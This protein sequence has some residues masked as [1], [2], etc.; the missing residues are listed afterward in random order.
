[1]MRV[2]VRRGDSL[3]YYSQLFFIPLPL[4]AD[5]N[6]SI[7]PNALQIGESV[8]IPGFTTEN[9]Y[10]KQG[11]SLWTVARRRNLALDAL[12]LLNP[13]LNPNNLQIGDR[14]IV[15]R[16]VVARVIEERRR[17]GSAQ[18]SADV[19]TL[20]TIYPFI[21]VTT[22]GRSVDNKPIR[23]MKIG[24]G[25]KKVHFNGSFH[26]NEWITSS[27][28]MTFLNDYLL[29]LTNQMAI[30]GIQAL[31][32]YLSTNISAVPMVNPDGVDLVLNGPSPQRRD[33]LIRINNGSTDFS[34]WKANI[35]SVD[36]N[37]QYPANW[38]IEKERK[39]PKAPAPRDFPGYRPLTEPEAIAMAELAQREDFDRMLAFHTQGQE[40]YWGYEGLEPEESARLAEIFERAS[41]YRAVRYIDSH[42]GY[43][44]W[45]IQQFRKPGFTIELGRGINPLPLS[46]FDEIYEDVLGIFLA[47]LYR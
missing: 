11:D 14:I 40:F 3:W 29:A 18:L 45:F 32:L 22:I 37:N 7:N 19:N 20:T 12:L 25:E 9:Y 46:Q 33:E 8:N 4:I 34:G 23:E 27:V 6:A 15:P 28:I 43:K 2:T 13:N 39:E 41:G 24:R 17:Y 31:P 44:D 30:R 21:R 36:L 10:V 26:A 1:M 47:S 35:R 16:R 42:A 5:S 38:E